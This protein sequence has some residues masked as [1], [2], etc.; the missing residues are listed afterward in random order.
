MD[1]GTS[2]PQILQRCIQN[3]GVSHDLVFVPLM[4]WPVAEVDALEL[5]NPKL[6]CAV[7]T[8]DR[9]DVVNDL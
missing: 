7:A 6:F 9:V 4:E 2:R 1:R 5:R 3:L 8:G